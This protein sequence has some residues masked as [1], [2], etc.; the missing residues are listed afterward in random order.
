MERNT[1]LTIIAALAEMAK[2]DLN[3]PTKTGEAIA[4]QIELLGAKVNPETVR[5]KLNEVRIPVEPCH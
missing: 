3:K 5:R 4:R 2:L 1:L